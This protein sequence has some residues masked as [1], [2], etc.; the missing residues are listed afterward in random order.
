MYNPRKVNFFNNL[1]SFNIWW[2]YRVT[3]SIV[4]DLWLNIKNR[5]HENLVYTKF[6][7]FY[8]NSRQF[9]RMRGKTIGNRKKQLAQSTNQTKFLLYS[10]AGWHFWSAVTILIRD[11]LHKKWRKKYAVVKPIPNPFHS[12]WKK[13]DGLNIDRAIGGRVYD[14]R[15]SERFKIHRVQRSGQDDTG[16]SRGPRGSRSSRVVSVSAIATPRAGAREARKTFPE[17]LGPRRKATV[18]F[19]LTNFPFVSAAERRPDRLLASSVR[20]ASHTATVQSAGRDVSG[21]AFIFGFSHFD[22][23]LRDTV[24]HAYSDR[25]ADSRMKFASCSRAERLPVS[26][27]A[28]PAGSFFSSGSRERRKPFSVHVSRIGGSQLCGHDPTCRSMTRSLES[29]I[30]AIAEW[31]FSA[32]VITTI[33]WS[34]L[35]RLRFKTNR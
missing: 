18:A 25:R 3:T 23:N 29:P 13:I 33:L 34:Q 21:H 2:K 4:F 32:F 35:D 20:R 7:S 28:G 16:N 17:D 26:G 12:K 6:Y 14:V 19:D 9:F 31:S 5:F 24:V 22:P 1:S 27:W 30:N 10:D 15:F 11:D 8:S